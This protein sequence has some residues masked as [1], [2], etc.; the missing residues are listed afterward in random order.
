M[1]SEN[2][3]LL[4]CRSRLKHAN[5]LCTQMKYKEASKILKNEILRPI[6]SRLKYTSCDMEL[7]SSSILVLPH[8]KDLFLLESSC[9]RFYQ[10]PFEMKSMFTSISKIRILLNTTNFCT[11]TQLMNSRSDLKF[12]LVCCWW[13]ATQRLKGLKTQERALT[14][15][16][17]LFDWS[18]SNI[19]QPLN[20]LTPPRLHF[21]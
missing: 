7:S 3:D 16:L 2:L 20:H 6:V 21:C 10:I 9:A 11:S 19:I 5:K 15:C 8:P 12:W 14:T 13:S 4:Q 1:E 18:A 17:R